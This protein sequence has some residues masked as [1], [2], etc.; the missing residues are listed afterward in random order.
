MQSW[1]QGQA[2][3]SGQLQLVFSVLH[4]RGTAKVRN[5]KIFSLIEILNKTVDNHCKRLYNLI[6]KQ[7]R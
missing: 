6:F 2:F 3:R 4:D 5:A 7:K 1:Q